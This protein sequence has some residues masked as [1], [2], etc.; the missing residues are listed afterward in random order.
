MSNL[1]NLKHHAKRY[2]A[3]VEVR[4]QR[5]IDLEVLAPDG[6][7]WSGTTL[8]S[9]VAEQQPG[10]KAVDVYQDL[11]AR[12]QGLEKCQDADCSTCEGEPC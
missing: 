3:T 5:P 4:R 11:V 8:H 9:L 1:A 2:C 7:V 12:M 10:Q 6:M